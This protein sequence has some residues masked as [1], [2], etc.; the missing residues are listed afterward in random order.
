LQN[1]AGQ[2]RVSY[3]MATAG[4]W[5]FKPV[6]DLNVTNVDMDGFTE[7]G[8]NGAA[9]RVSSNDETVFSATP[10]LEIGTQWGHPGGTLV[11]PYIRGGVSFYD[12]ADF[13]IAA[14]FAAAPGVAP[15]TTN[16]N[17]DDVLGDVS[18]GLSLL[19]ARGGVLT[20]SY[21]GRFGDTFQE[22]SVSARA[23]V[24]LGA[25]RR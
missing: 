5:Y 8:G 23:S 24:P 9:L 21:D 10:A 17:I 18:A 14:S 22:N 7:K 11:R 6:V 13:P 16:G 3:L 2:L 20:F 19:G 4:A 15:F 1:V 12:D 25:W